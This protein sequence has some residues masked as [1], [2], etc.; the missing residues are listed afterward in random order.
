MRLHLLFVLLPLT[1]LAKP[2]V[3]FIVSD[4]MRPNLGAY[5]DVNEGVFEAPPMHTPNLDKVKA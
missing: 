5:A 1:S 4:D 3:L 2:N